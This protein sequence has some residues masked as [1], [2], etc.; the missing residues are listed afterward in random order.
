ML[1]F[2]FPASFWLKRNI[3]LFSLQ[4]GKIIIS[5]P[6]ILTLPQNGCQGLTI[7]NN[8]V[9]IFAYITLLYFL[10]I[11]SYS[12]ASKKGG[13]RFPLDDNIEGAQVLYL[14]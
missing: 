14:K 4:F 12:P 10:V 8:G 6:W 9:F 5:F 1:P 2:Y 3:G 13:S 11:H 7:M